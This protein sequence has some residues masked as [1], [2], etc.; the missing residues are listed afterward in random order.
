M[1]M[2][3]KVFLAIFLWGL[4]NFLIG[5]GLKWYQLELVNSSLP[6]LYPWRF[7]I[8]DGLS[9]AIT[10]SI[11]EGVLIVLLQEISKG[12]QKKGMMTYAFLKPLCLFAFLSSYP[13]FINHLLSIH[14]G[15]AIVFLFNTYGLKSLANCIESLFMP[16]AMLI[17]IVLYYW[18]LFSLKTLSAP[19]VMEFSYNFPSALFLNMEALSSLQ[20]P[21]WMA[22]TALGGYSL[23]SFLTSN[24]FYM[25]DV[26]M[27]WFKPALSDLNSMLSIFRLS[28]SSQLLLGGFGYYLLLRKS[29]R[30]SRIFAAAFGLMS[31]I[32]GGFSYRHANETWWGMLC[33]I[34]PWLW[35]MAMQ[36]SESWT[37][38]LFWGSLAGFI[39]ML[40]FINP[41][42]YVIFLYSVAFYFLVL[43]IISATENRVEG[44]K[45]LANGAFFSCLMLIVNYRFIAALSDYIRHGQFPIDQQLYILP[46]FNKGWPEFVRHFGILQIAEPSSFKDFFWGYGICLLAII[47]L[48]FI[49][50]LR[51]TYC[52]KTSALGYT[53]IILPL[54]WCLIT[55]GDTA[56][57]LRQFHIPAI[58]GHSLLRHVTIIHSSIVFFSAIGATQLLRWSHLNFLTIMKSPSFLGTISFGLF[59][60]TLLYFNGTT[61]PHLIWPIALLFVPFLGQYFARLLI[62]FGLIISAIWYYPKEASHLTIFGQNPIESIAHNPPTQR[63]AAYSY[64]I[65]KSWQ[66]NIPETYLPYALDAFLRNP[67][68]PTNFRYLKDVLTSINIKLPKVSIENGRKYLSDFDTRSALNLFLQRYPGEDHRFSRFFTYPNSLGFEYGSVETGRRGHI[69]GLPLERLGYTGIIYGG[70]F[71]S[72]SFFVNAPS[73]VSWYKTL[74]FYAGLPSSDSI[75]YHWDMFTNLNTSKASL[76]NFSYFYGDRGPISEKFPSLDKNLTIHEQDI[77]GAPLQ[78][79]RNKAVMPRAF[80]F[81]DW[82]E[83]DYDLL[84]QKGSDRS[85]TF[86]LGNKWLSEVNILE[87]LILP[88]TKREDIQKWIGQPL[89]QKQPITDAIEDFNILGNFA[90]FKIKK[91]DRPLP[92]FY[93]DMY[94]RDWVAFEGGEERPVWPGQLSF[95]A[96]PVVRGDNLV[97]ME[98]RPISLLAAKLFTQ[99][100]LLIGIALQLQKIRW[101]I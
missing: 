56:V 4:T 71:E 100:I 12:N 34:Y 25:L 98:F 91:I 13:I 16:V 10:I 18:P 5:L 2:D 99:C 24:V 93:S 9:S 95:K 23:I 101:S 19:D 50:S 60:T 45:I 84:N 61:F 26:L 57:F 39:P 46:S 55:S 86:H 22:R 88:S 15:F 81:N 35:Y 69:A 75:I 41:E 37:K 77:P 51:K 83:R 54:I 53:L 30:C 90:A 27:L 80:F 8:F 70:L 59:Y 31:V 68:I 73:A 49:S 94:H 76:L 66:K 14:A 17:G 21:A 62:V 82:L 42:V 64:G 7:F 58:P 74:D 79:V 43:A 63:I 89:G 87:T 67:Q 38:T 47:G 3:L 78:I 65:R 52:K 11:A 20:E 28:W 1:K 96:V 36:G 72:S 33:Y 40:H 97:W 92:L 48:P 32:C 44:L 29:L 85:T 6:S